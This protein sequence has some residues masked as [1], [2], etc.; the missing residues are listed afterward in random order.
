VYRCSSGDAAV[1]LQDTPCAPGQEQQARAHTRPVDPPPVAKAA[2][3]ALSAA[4]PAPGPREVR[5][6]LVTPQPLYDCE[7][8]DGSTYESESGI[9]QRQWVPLWVMRHDTDA[10]RRTIGSVGRPSPSFATPGIDPR[11]TP[12]LAYPGGTWVEDRC[13]RLS[14]A[15]ACERRHARLRDLR[16]RWS[17]AFPSERARIDSEHDGLREQLREECGIS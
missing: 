11:S 4:S 17:N 10:P 14:A 5:V 3:P 7:R 13:Y 2:I 9:P 6:T 12:V 15:V 16:R 8:H 1:S